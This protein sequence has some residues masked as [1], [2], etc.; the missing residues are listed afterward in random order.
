VTAALLEVDSDTA[1]EVV[2]GTAGIVVVDFSAEWC[3]PCRMLA[4]VLEQLDR[5]TD[6]LTV[7]QV[8]VDASPDLA[9]AHAV[10]SFPTLIFFADGRPVHRL[11]GS[12]GIGSL[13]E[14]LQRVRSALTAES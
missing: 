5:E 7:V 3:A 9:T 8:D 2:G 10:M 12:R 11:V 4:P 14:E 6:D 13:R 1:R